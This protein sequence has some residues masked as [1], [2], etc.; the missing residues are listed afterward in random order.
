MILLIK[1][2]L[3]L[4]FTLIIVILNVLSMSVLLV[5]LHIGSKEV[6]KKHLIEDISGEYLP[7]YRLGGLDKITQIYDEDYLQ[8]IDRQGKIIGY[9]QNIRRIA[10]EPD[11]SLV[12][13]ALSGKTIFSEVQ[14]GTG[15]YLTSYFPLDKNT[16]GQIAMSIDPMIAY[17]NNFIKLVLFSIPGMLLLS[18]LTS[19]ILVVYALKPAV[20][21]C[22][23]QENF[24][25]NISHELRS[26]LTSL[27]GNLEVSLRKDRTAGEYKETLQIGLNETRRIIDL[28]NNLGLLASSRFKPLDIVSSQIGLDG[29]LANV[30]GSFLPQIESKAIELHMGEIAHIKCFCDESLIKRA[31][32]NLIDNA[33]KYTPEKGKIEITFSQDSRTIYLTI[34]NSARDIHRDEFKDLL[35]PFY[36]G[37]SIS[38]ADIEGKGLGLHIAAYII[39]S[40]RGEIKIALTPDRM[41]SVTITLPVK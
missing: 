22:E 30:I 33:V 1:N 39:H 19:R 26:P 23:F 20:E 16:A 5:Y 9:T 8:V 37:R 38:S 11:L 2:R 17:E 29:I 32:E 28:L 7:N 6:C 12:R 25:S 14:I 41:F 3:V 34:S 35:E 4:V 18:Y 40:H 24:L 10:V 27:Q 21:F 36:R 13:Q 31:I 15:H